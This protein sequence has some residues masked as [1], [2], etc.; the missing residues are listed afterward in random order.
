MAQG[1]FATRHRHRAEKC[2]RFNAVGH[3]AV[4]AA[5]QFVHAFHYHGRCA[6]AADFRAHFHQAFRQIHHFWLNRAVFQRGNALC[7]RCRH[8][9]V[10]RA[11]HGYHVHH[12]ARALQF[13]LRRNGFHIAVFNGDL[14]AHGFQAFEMLIH[15]AAANRAAPRQAYFGFAK[16]R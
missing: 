14:R 4:F 11:A 5:V 2:A 16:A 10:F 1:Y 8:Q 9:Q 7:Q 12:H 6:D 13:A 15:R 3:Y